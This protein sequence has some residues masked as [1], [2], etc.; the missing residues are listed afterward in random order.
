MLATVSWKFREHGSPEQ[1]GGGT[2]KSQRVPSQSIYGQSGHPKAN[3]IRF[4]TRAVTISV[5][6]GSPDCLMV[7]LAVALL[8]ADVTGS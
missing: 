5:Q 8:S 2:C 6:M 7:N 3:A 1:Q 4:S